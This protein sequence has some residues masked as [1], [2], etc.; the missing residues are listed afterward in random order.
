MQRPHE[1]ADGRT[2][3]RVPDDLWELP[4]PG[5]DDELVTSAVLSKDCPILRARMA[6]FLRWKREAHDRLLDAGERGE[7]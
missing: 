4:L 6:E 1:T 5:D 3:A 7:A 2:V